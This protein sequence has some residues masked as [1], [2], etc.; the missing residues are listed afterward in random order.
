MALVMCES[1]RLVVVV[2]VCRLGEGYVCRCGGVFVG[3][4]GGGRHKEYHAFCCA[5][6]YYGIIVL[7]Q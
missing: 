7:V 5:N 6:L 2:C 4:S 3:V 1:V